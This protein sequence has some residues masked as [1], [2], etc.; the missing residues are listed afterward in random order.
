MLIKYVLIIFPQLNDTVQSLKYQFKEI[1]DVCNYLEKVSKNYEIVYL[2]YFN[3][4]KC[5]DSQ[6]WRCKLIISFAH[7]P[8]LLDMRLLGLVSVKL[9]SRAYFFDCALSWWPHF[10]SLLASAFQKWIVQS[11]IKWRCDVIYR[12]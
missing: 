12:H 1:F 3:K 5:N 2:P 7:R 6:K 4:K 8:H 9:G 10:R 11:I